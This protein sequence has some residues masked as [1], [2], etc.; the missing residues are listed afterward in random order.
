MRLG[1]HPVWSRL[2]DYS[3]CETGIP[4]DSAVLTHVM[5]CS[6]C[7]SDVM[8]IRRARAQLDR[9]AAPEPRDVLSSVLDRRQRGER[10]LLPEAIHITGGTS[11]KLGR[12]SF[13]AVVVVLLVGALLNVVAEANAPVGELVIRPER[14]RA[15]AALDLRY[16]PMSRFAGEAEL[17]VR[18]RYRTAADREYEGSIRTI[19]VARLHPARGGTFRGT[20]VLPE[21]VVYAAFAVE[22]VA[23]E[24]IDH[25]R[26]RLWDLV[27][28]DPKGAPRLDALEQRVRDMHGRS[29]RRMLE[30]AECMVAH[31]PDHPRSWARL[32]YARS[33][34]L[35]P[36]AV[37]LARRQ[38]E[39]HIAAMHARLDTV[40]DLP[41]DITVAMAEYSQRSDW[42][43]RAAAADP[44][45][46]T[47]LLWEENR[48]RLQFTND[49][50]AYFEAME[51]L[52]RAAEH[53]IGPEHLWWIANAAGR[54]RHEGSTRDLI[55]WTSRLIDHGRPHD[56]AITQFLTSLLDRVEL[57]PAA[58]ELIEAQIATWQIGDDTRRALST[59]RGDHERLMRQNRAA[60]HAA[61]GRLLVAM[62]D[63]RRGYDRMQAAADSSWDPAVFKVAADLAVQMG[64]TATAFRNFARLAVEP[65]LESYADSA[66]KVSGPRFEPAFWRW[67]VSQAQEELRSSLIIEDGFATV[68]ADVTLRDAGGRRVRAADLLEPAAVIAVWPS[69]L[70]PSEADLDRLGTLQQWA[71]P[72]GIRVLAIM[73]GT[74]DHR[75]R[76]RSAESPETPIYFAADGFIDS[77]LDGFS[78][79]ALWVVFTRDSQL[80]LPTSWEDVRR[81]AT[82]LVDR[83]TTVD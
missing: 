1:R 28:H 45:H 67:L 63:V 53:T 9:V 57:R 17:V 29:W 76:S 73:A 33:Q 4:S 60:L 10:L 49:Q 82:A 7:R 19:E 37:E 16:R 30:T 2:L 69:Y 25:N 41:P 74:A 62:G 18:A 13:A 36:R 77:G 39:E 40:L 64:D 56:R 48:L 58:L 80:L 51:M 3:L 38:V 50:H 78:V 42:R 81:H 65:G 20:A 23:G 27:I 61:A 26:H 66:R 59:P 83:R 22:D 35:L 11:P 47:V 70:G 12:L 34:L 5:S 31:H 14:P 24:I 79:P 55:R 46:A 44:T 72:R 43:E 15:G 68:S 52:W 71:G 8:W 54:A 32:A 75:Y 21:S 6:R